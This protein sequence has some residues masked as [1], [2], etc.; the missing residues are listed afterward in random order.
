[1]AKEKTII[2][3]KQDA[4]HYYVKA[5]KRLVWL[6]ATSLTAIITSG[7]ATLLT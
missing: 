4:E 7:L 2:V 5:N 6:L 1:M 3:L